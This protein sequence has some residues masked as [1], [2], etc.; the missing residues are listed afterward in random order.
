VDLTSRRERERLSSA[1]VRTS[2]DIATRWNIRDENARMLLGMVQRFHFS[3][4]MRGSVAKISRSNAI[5][6]LGDSQIAW[7]PVARR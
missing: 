3:A 6:D 5:P 2:F 4:A 7:V 1:A